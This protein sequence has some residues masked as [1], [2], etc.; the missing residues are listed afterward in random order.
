MTARDGDGRSSFI[1]HVN[2]KPCV[3]QQSKLMF[4]GHV[5]PRLSL[6]NMKNSQENIIEAPSAVNVFV[7]G[8]SQG[9]GLWDSGSLGICRW[10]EAAPRLQGLPP[11]PGVQKCHF[12]SYRVAAFSRGRG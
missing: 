9:L 3:S 4:P 8:R 10:A 2:T 12:L 11:F 1:H 7:A 6:K 5:K